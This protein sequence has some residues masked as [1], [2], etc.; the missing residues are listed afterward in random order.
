M[1]QPSRRVESLVADG[2]GGL[3]SGPCPGAPLA[4]LGIVADL[5]ARVLEAEAARRTLELARG[6]WGGVDAVVQLGDLTDGSDGAA[7]DAVAGLAGLL[8][9]QLDATGAS[10]VHVLGN[11][12]TDRLD[13][14]GWAAAV[15]GVG[16]P[17]EV[18]AGGVRVLALDSCRASDGRP[19]G[20]GAS[21]WT[22][23]WVGEAQLGW[24]ASRLGAS[25]VPALVALH[26]RADTDGRY[27]PRDAA[28][29]RDVVAGHASVRCVV[30]GHAHRSQ[31]RVR[32]GVLWLGWGRLTAGMAVAGP[33]VEVFADGSVRAMGFGV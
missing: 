23:A 16:C 29:L 6:S 13:V 8:A 26:H 24:L 32:D 3:R 27:A 28:R 7:P 5:H 22:A 31:A 10:V 12:D 33:A 2:S 19:S 17:C 20:P 14:S 18:R 4:R 21:D 25:S 30:M 11:H 1:S 15:G 9:R